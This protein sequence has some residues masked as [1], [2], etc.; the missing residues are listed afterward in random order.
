MFWEER[1]RYEE[2]M[3]WFWRHGRDHRGPPPMRPP[4]GPGGPPPHMMVSIICYVLCQ[5]FCSFLFSFSYLFLIFFF[6]LSQF[7]YWLNWKF[8]I[9]E[10]ANC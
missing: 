1:R 4:F 3:E 10:R 9:K 5:L 2:E 7:Y 6:L 8:I